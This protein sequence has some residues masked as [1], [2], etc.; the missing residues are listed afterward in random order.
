MVS[1]MENKQESGMNGMNGM[2]GKED[3]MNGM[4]GREE[5]KEWKE[6][7]GEM[8]WQITSFL[9]ETSRSI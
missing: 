4:E 3:G 5:R 6:I 2:N 1:E 9:G 8:E 7:N